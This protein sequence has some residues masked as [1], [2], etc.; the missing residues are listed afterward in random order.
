M[1]FFDWFKTKEEPK[2]EIRFK[3]VEKHLEVKLLSSEVRLT[4]INGEVL[5]FSIDGGVDKGWTEKYSLLTGSITEDPYFV[6]NNGKWKP[7][8]WVVYCH[9][10][11]VR[12]RPI[13]DLDDVLVVSNENGAARKIPRTSILKAEIFEPKESGKTET[14]TMSFLEP[15]E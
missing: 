1:G 8:P 9:S 15:I 2:Q 14:V 11:P 12:L 7:R 6:D 5:N 3:V 13:F 4:L 10:E